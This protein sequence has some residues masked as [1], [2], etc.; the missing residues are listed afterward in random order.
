MP[1]SKKHKTPQ[2]HKA[3]TPKYGKRWTTNLVDLE[4]PS[5]ELCQVRRP[6]VQGLIKA[7]VL[8]SLDSLTAIVQ[9]ETIPNSEGKPI[10]KDKSIDSVVKDPVKFGK[11]ME[12]TDKIVC[13]VV[14]QPKVHSNLRPV[15]Q[16]VD[17]EN[18]LWEDVTKDGEKVFE[19]I[20][21]EERD[22]ELVYVDY[23]DAIDKM[24]IM[25]F[26]VGG[27]ADLV[28]FRAQTQASMGGVPAGEAAAPAAE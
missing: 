20:P 27:S 21:E 5:G 25:N 11:M 28:E 3:K 19:E 22:P 24:F 15:R 2:D 10:P 13:Y 17:E 23:I 7:G 16:L 14:T 9:T 26:A 12:Q 4:L 18:D 8:H 6:G 1:S